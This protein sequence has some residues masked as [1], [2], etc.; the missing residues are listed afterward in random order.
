M[1]HLNGMGRVMLPCSLHM[2]RQKG[3]ED[4]VMGGFLPPLN[5]QSGKKR[6]KDNKKL[7]RRDSSIYFIRKGHV[8]Y[9]HECA[10]WY[11]QVE[12]AGGIFP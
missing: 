7:A 1:P 12:S 10:C 3:G 9:I 8:R 2:L 11:G 4:I 6:D 5:T